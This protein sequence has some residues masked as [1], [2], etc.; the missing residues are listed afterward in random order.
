MVP[1]E[2]PPEYMDINGTFSILKNIYFVQQKKEMYKLKVWNGLRVSKWWQ[3]GG[4]KTISIHS[5]DFPNNQYWK[6]THW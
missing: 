3:N 6:I 5:V 1:Y 2:T 4:V